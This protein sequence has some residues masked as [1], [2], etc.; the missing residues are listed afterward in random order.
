MKR[1]N[2]FFISFL[3]LTLFGSSLVR[4]SLIDCMLS[5]SPSVVGKT[6]ATLTIT[7]V[8]LPALTTSFTLTLKSTTGS[9][10]DYFQG[11]LTAS[12]S[13]SSSPVIDATASTVTIAYSSGTF[14]ATTM[15]ITI[16]PFITPANTCDHSFTITTIDTV[17]IYMTVSAGTLS[18][19]TVTPDSSSKVGGYYPLTLIL[20]PSSSISST[21]IIKISTVTL[22]NSPSDCTSL[23]TRADY[24]TSFTCAYSSNIITITISALNQTKI[25]S[26]DSLVLIISDLFYNTVMSAQPITVQTA[27]SSCSVESSTNSADW[28]P[29]SAASFQTKTLTIKS[30]PSTCSV[31]SLSLTLQPTVAFGTSQYIVFDMNEELYAV[32]PVTCLRLTFDSETSKKLRATLDLGTWSTSSTVSLTFSSFVFPPTEKPFSIDIT[33]YSGTTISASTVVHKDTSSTTTATRN[34]TTTA[35]LVTLSGVTT[36]SEAGTYN[37][38]ISVLCY[39]TTSTVFE[40]TLP[41]DLSTTSTLCTGVCSYTSAQEFTINNAVTTRV[42]GGNT[43]TLSFKALNAP[44]VQSVTGNFVVS[45]KDSSYYSFVLTTSLASGQ[46]YTHGTFTAFTI[47]PSSVKCYA[48]TS[49]SLKITVNH[50]LPSGTIITFTFPPDVTYSSATLSSMKIDGTTVNTASFTLSTLTVSNGITSTVTNGK[51]IEIV[52][53]GIV[54]PGMMGTY[55]GFAAA[56]TLSGNAIDSLSG[57]NMAIT[58]PAPA[59]VTC[60]KDSEINAAS[61]TY[62]F[63]FVSPNI[64][65]PYG[66]NSNY[67][68][69]GI[70]SDVPSCDTSTLAAY[71]TSDL[72][73]NDI[74]TGNPFYFNLTFVTKPT[75]TVKFKLTCVNPLSTKPSYDFKLTM[76]SRGTSDMEILMG[77]CSVTTSIGRDLT[78]ASSAVNFPTFPGYSTLTSLTVTRVDTTLPIKRLVIGVPEVNTSIA[79]QANVAVSYTCAYSISSSGLVLELASNI[80]TQQITISNI[81]STNP[82]TV[83]LASTSS[84]FT[85]QSYSCVG[86]SYYLVDK[87]DNAGKLIVSCNSPCKTCNSGLPNECLSCVSLSTQYYYFPDSYVCKIDDGTTTVCG[88]GYYRD[89]T[90]LRC[91]KCSSSCTECSTSTT[92]CTSCADTTKVIYE[93]ACI[94]ACYDGYYAPAVSVF[95]TKC[96][97]PCYKCQAPGTSCLSCV[98]GYYL[99]GTQC[100]S[101]CGSQYFKNSSTQICDA[102]STSCYNCSGSSTLCT[103]CLNQ[104]LLDAQCVSSNTC[105]SDNKHIANTSTYVCDTCDSSCS[106]CSGSTTTCTKCS[107]TL[108]LY[109]T[110]CI[111]NCP[112]QYYA[113]SNECK[114]CNASCNGCVSTA[115]H[116]LACQTGMYLEEDTYNCVIRCGTNYYLSGNNCVK[117]YSSCLTCSQSPT[118]CTSCGSSLFLSENRCVS[119]CPSGTFGENN[120]CKDC[121]SSCATCN[122]LSTNCTSCSASKLMYSNSCVSTCPSGTTAISSECQSCTGQCASCTGTV[123]YCT[124]CLNPVEYAYAGQCL[125]ACPTNTLA[126]KTGQTCVACTT[127]CDV[128]TWTSSSTSSTT[129]TCNKCTSGYKYLSGACYY[130]CPSGYSTSSDGLSCVS[131]GN[132]NTGDNASS[133]SNSESSFTLYVPPHFIA[134]IFFIIVSIASVV[135]NKLASVSG[136]IA[137][138]ISYTCFTSYLHQIILS[139]M[140]EE[141]FLYLGTGIIF[142]VNIFL[143]LFF[144]IPYQSK[145]SPDIGFK[146]WAEYHSCTKTWILSLSSILS[147][148]SNRLFYS[149]IFGFE[150][151]YV[152]FKDFWNLFTPI[153]LFSVISFMIVYVPI[154]GIDCYALCNIDKGNWLYIVV[155]ESLTLSTIMIITILVIICYSKK[156]ISHFNKNTNYASMFNDTSL[157]E[158][159]NKTKQFDEEGIRRK[160]LEDVLSR[161]GL[162]RSEKMGSENSDNTAN[163]SMTFRGGKLV[164]KRRRSMPSKSQ[165]AKTK[166]PRKTHSYPSSPKTANSKRVP[167]K[168]Y[169]IDEKPTN[170]DP[171][172]LPN[173]VYSEAIPAR[174]PNSIQVRPTTDFGNQTPPF[175]KIAAFKKHLQAQDKKKPRKGKKL[176]E[177]DR[178]ASP[179]E[180]IEELPE[181]K[182][183]YPY[184]STP[185]NGKRKSNISEE[186]K[187]SLMNEY[188]RGPNKKGI[189]PDENMDDMPTEHKGKYLQNLDQNEADNSKFCKE[190]DQ[191]LF[192]ASSAAP[193]ET[194]GMA[195]NNPFGTS[196]ND[197]GN[198]DSE[199]NRKMVLISPTVPLDPNNASEE[200]KK[201]THQKP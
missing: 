115:S 100:L 73:I 193:G 52:L 19:F 187:G 26:S 142:G 17:T 130:V 45:V 165:T 162:S 106:E 31:G 3:L 97:S 86:S 44:S 190:T 57:Q 21:G 90:N 34:S 38:P 89:S 128:C 181:E 172:M 132:T 173:N 134:S 67:L 39:L 80:T 95:C 61:N 33:T 116:C 24:I 59:T 68:R 9:I 117:C 109:G 168:K 136:N 180:V 140:E 169:G 158:E 123:S 16:S 148:Q 182:E 69:V 48:Q 147:F 170:I 177:M 101:D 124:E 8:H 55:T 171:E 102:C 184:D 63:S 72:T 92:N 189:F 149:R 138:L 110:T 120:K 36:V 83:A 107:G 125:T 133:S 18:S 153:N 70:P 154:I 197:I 183:D 200:K 74:I 201:N 11:T 112:T 145:V 118:S 186:E 79:C 104:Y 43:F 174:D 84:S 76:L 4:A 7:C 1:E 156:E 53:D 129:Q 22:K 64:P 126:S 25:T 2:G 6:T 32:T 98:S 54:N 87:A 77:E 108:N 141:S 35:N 51:V 58:E 93:G 143:N 94:S 41:S 152:P 119:T 159:L 146:R 139:L 114:S 166:D 121:D 105:I 27:E 5:S 82:A 99:K 167:L 135:I 78:V 75:K 113:S 30:S 40:L 157:T 194:S 127:G 198:M 151:L 20:T 85:V 199:L 10:S 176:F 50:K 179:L 15:T 131:S 196:A 164:P 178:N 13:G 175:D 155:I 91:E 29:A 160:V 111:S 23:V 144:W 71:S 88:S 122:L 46:T 188:N 195:G 161:L 191:E 60:T 65:L 56:A 42:E 150:L 66:A 49:Y 12:P 47:T 81:G 185:L 96:T 137:C 103:S 163:K 28:I 192:E 14:S 37:I 62:T